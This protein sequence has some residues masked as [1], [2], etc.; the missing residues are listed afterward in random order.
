MPFKHAQP[1]EWQID[2]KCFICKIVVAGDYCALTKHLH[3]IHR[4]KT[5]NDRKCNVICS[6]NGCTE[7]F[8]IF[9]SYRLHLKCCAKKYAIQRNERIVAPPVHRPQNREI[10]L[11]QQENAKHFVVSFENEFGDCDEQMEVEEPFCMTR[12][13]AKLMLKLKAEQNVTHSALNLLAR[14]L[15]EILRK[16]YL[17]RNECPPKT[18]ESLHQLNT[19]EKRTNKIEK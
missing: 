9:G 18:C 16:E 12:E 10:F 5:S 15:E 3:K 1:V 13:V 17:S 4:F 19:Q 2:F 14:G 7:M 8:N 11:Q 6:Q